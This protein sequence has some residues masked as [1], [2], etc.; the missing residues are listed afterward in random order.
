MLPEIGNLFIHLALILE[1][2]CFFILLVDNRLYRLV[3]YLSYFYSILAFAS[4]A[5]LAYSYYASDFS[6]LS[7]VTSSQINNPIM[8]KIA[9]SWSTHEGSMLLWNCY[10]VLFT[11]LMILISPSS[12]LVTRY[13]VL[14]QTF[15]NILFAAF[16]VFNSN[17]FVRIFPA[18]YEGIGFNPILQDIALL[19]HPPILYLGYISTSVLYSITVA[20]CFARNQLQHWY[21]LIKP[22]IYFA[23]SFLTA[24]IA[25][26]SWWAYREI[27][28]G[29]FWFWDPVEN[30][31]LM[32]WLAITALL[33]LIPIVKRKIGVWLLVAMSIAFFSFVLT[34][35]GTI[36][37]RS[38]LITSVHS[39]A[40][41]ANRG[42]AILA[43]LVIILLL[44]GVA[45]VF[46]YK[47]IMQNKIHNK[48]AN[49]KQSSSQQNKFETKTD[50]INQKQHIFL[51]TI[52][53]III[54]C[55]LVIVLLGTLF[56][57]AAKLIL[58]L[59]ITT[60][61]Q[62]FNALLGPF[63]VGIVVCCIIV[64]VCFDRNSGTKNNSYIMVLPHCFI[65]IVGIVAVIN[66]GEQIMPNINKISLTN[67]VALLGFGSS[68]M[69]YTITLQ[70]IS[71]LILSKLWRNSGKFLYIW[72]HL[73]VATVIAG[74]SL[75]SYL[76]YEKQKVLYPV[77]TREKNQV[78]NNNFIRLN[79]YNIT[80]HD[81]GYYTEPNYTAKVMHLK[82][83]DS[84]NPNS[85][86]SLYPELRSYSVEKKNT[87]ETAIFSTPLYDIYIGVNQTDFSDDVII[88][89]YYRPGINL[90]WL[91]ACLMFLCGIYRTFENMLM[92]LAES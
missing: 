5:I 47:T 42:L 76:G 72:G 52:N 49:K 34:V 65:A 60:D 68:I 44:A 61:P 64:I 20:A 63:G 31:S 83:T 91:G 67:C 69:L 39:F 50:L 59:E 11:S 18:P 35:V 17:P 12:S 30:A 46:A 86:S 85:V 80:L 40:T 16:T 7:V 41:D 9:A 90:I 45:L 81:I 55:V 74:I 32:P 13:S 19:I 87:V 14:I 29:G 56:P 43:G 2:L 48:L 77:L 26:G 84:N 66:Y 1:L 37:V 51:I 8:Y 15:L 23:W 73:A 38:G 4:F 54:G 25:L 24:G 79:Q 75:C 6:M 82:L 78:K 71:R 28:W 33:H 10:M 3:G 36:I 92:L 57:L 21:Y 62:Y 22:W 88:S 58:G 27:G 70:M 53:T 89:A